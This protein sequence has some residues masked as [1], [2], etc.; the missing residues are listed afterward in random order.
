MYA[1][2]RMVHVLGSKMIFKN[3]VYTLAWLIGLSLMCGTIMKII[4]Y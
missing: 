1:C 2:T 3:Q 4:D